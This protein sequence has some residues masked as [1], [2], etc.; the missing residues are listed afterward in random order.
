MGVGTLVV[1]DEDEASAEEPQLV[2]GDATP[3][4]LRGFDIVVSVALVVFS[5]QVRRDGLPTDGFWFDDSWVAAGARY[6]RPDNILMT[7]SG[8]PGLTTLLSLVHHVGGRGAWLAVPALVVGSLAATTAYWFSRALQLRRPVALLVASFLAVAPVHIMYSAR[9]KGYVIDTLMITALTLLVSRLAKVRWSWRTAVGWTAFALIAG[10][11]SGY[12]LVGTAIATVILAVHPRRDVVFRVGALGVQGLIQLGYFLTA[13][14]YT[15]LDGIEAVMERVYDGHMTFHLNP[16]DFTG[17]TLKHLHRVGEVYPSGPDAWVTAFVVT[18][19]VGLVVGAIGPLSRWRNPSYQALACRYGL[20]LVAFAFCGSMIDR[21]PF[22]TTN[23]N[24]L[25]YGGRHTLWLVPSIL[26]GL[27][28]ALERV[29]TLL[30]SHLSVRRATAAVAIVAASAV[31]VH[32]HRPPTPHPDRGGATVVR[33]IDETIRPGDVLLVTGTVTFVFMYETTLPVELVATPHHQVG[34]AP[35]FP[36]HSIHAFEAW[37]TEPWTQD[38]V[39][40]LVADAD[41]VLVFGGGLVGQG[42]LETLNTWVEEAGFEP[43][44]STQHGSHRFYILEP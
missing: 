17:E 4:L 40:E 43:A 1:E 20:A 14:R 26:L 44:D 13:R 29:W 28:V 10:T 23:E 2:L 24:G 36:D 35:T 34:F 6:A 7:G 11:L 31:L 15:D 32:G 41:R 37:G 8:H 19:L 21:F 33:E 9:A 25:S 39:T 22:G 38:R 16:I 30:P 5:F 12:V 18:A 27:G 42:R 3:R